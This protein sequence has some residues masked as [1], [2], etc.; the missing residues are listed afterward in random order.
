M[1]TLDGIL[2]EKYAKYGM[3]VP[4]LEGKPAT[5]S[6]ITRKWESAQAII[7]KSNPM[8][9]FDTVLD[10]WLTAGLEAIRTVS[11]LRHFG[12]LI[13]KDGITTL[14]RLRKIYGIFPFTVEIDNVNANR[15]CVKMFSPQLNL[16]YRYPDWDS[17]R[18][19]VKTDQKRKGEVKI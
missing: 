5:T 4:G 12:F 8:D 16:L 11:D 18:E 19:L 15:S 7:V 1:K 14:D 6:Q 13:E 2:A 10:E 9:W 17:I 3:T